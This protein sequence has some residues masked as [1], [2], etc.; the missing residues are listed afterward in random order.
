MRPVRAP[1]RAGIGPA[2]LLLALATLPGGAGAGDGGPPAVSARP[3][4]PEAGRIG[5]ITRDA[6]GHIVPAG[7]AA[8]AE[9]PARDGAMTS[10]GNGAGMPP[11]QPVPQLSSFDPQAIAAVQRRR[12]HEMQAQK[13]QREIDR[14]VRGARR[15]GARRRRRP[16]R[17][18]GARGRADRRSGAD[19]Q[20]R[21]RA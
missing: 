2:A 9:P 20:G 8:P 4:L 21:A 6:N 19:R 10:F 14:I 15:P 1:W 18:N 17:P 3:A 13:L 7:P 5:R 12:D 11:P 16:P